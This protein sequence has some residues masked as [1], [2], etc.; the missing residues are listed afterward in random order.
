MS[1]RLGGNGGS[2][3]ETTAWP[4]PWTGSPAVTIPA[5]DLCPPFL[6]RKHRAC[7]CMSAVNKWFLVHSWLCCI[8]CL[9]CAFFF[10]PLLS[11]TFLLSFL[12]LAPYCLPAHEFVQRD[13]GSHHVGALWIEVL[14]HFSPLLSLFYFRHP[15]QTS[16]VF[17]DFSQC[18]SSELHVEFCIAVAS[19]KKKN[20]R[21]H[22]LDS[23]LFLFS[24]DQYTEFEA[25]CF[26]NKD[27]IS[28]DPCKFLPLTIYRQSCL[29]FPTPLHMDYSSRIGSNFKQ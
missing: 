16:V 27:K 21:R 13:K 6:Q 11:P 12:L 10:L 25:P 8:Q 1:L 24:F 20:Q 22:K 5:P 14:L 29:Y 19:T 18:F 9:F 26:Q 15:G 28:V 7:E 23:T 2:Q 4:A 17:F 3:S